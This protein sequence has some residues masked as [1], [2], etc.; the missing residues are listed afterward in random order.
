MSQ[1]VRFNLVLLRTSTFYEVSASSSIS[2]NI[3]S[4]KLF[5]Q[6]FAQKPKIEKR[7]TTST[8]S[9]SLLPEAVPWLELSVE[10]LCTDSESDTI[11]TCVCTFTDAGALLL[12]GKADTLQQDRTPVSS[13]LKCKQDAVVFMQLPAAKLP[14]LISIWAKEL[15]A[16]RTAPFALSL[17]WCFLP[18]AHPFSTSSHGAL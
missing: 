6:S 14:D 1:H 9:P 7:G 17:S 12:L 2:G 11:I 3:S 13:E 16:P 5:N 10:H 8:K 15:S 4:S 18:A